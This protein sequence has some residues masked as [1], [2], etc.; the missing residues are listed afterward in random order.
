MCQKRVNYVKKLA[1]NLAQYGVKLN[2]RELHVLLTI[3]KDQVEE[4]VRY[5]CAKRNIVIAGKP[6]MIVE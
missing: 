2:E 6:I 3:N 1:S 4:T 5:I